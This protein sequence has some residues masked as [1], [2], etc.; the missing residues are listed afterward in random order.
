MVPGSPAGGGGGG[1]ILGGDV[2]QHGLCPAWQSLFAARPALLFPMPLLAAA[3][4]VQIATAMHDAMH[5]KAVKLLTMG[6]LSSGL[7]LKL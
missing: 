5:G 3:R 2:C 1:G 6:G 4:F 7:S